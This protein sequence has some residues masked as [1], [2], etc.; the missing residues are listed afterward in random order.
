MYYT[1]YN[2][3]TGEEVYVPKSNEE[4]RMQRALLQYNKKENYK[5]VLKALE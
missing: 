5:L 4:K 2:P 1:E 3:L